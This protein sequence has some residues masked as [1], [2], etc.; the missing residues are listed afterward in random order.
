M[1]PVLTGEASPPGSEPAGDCCEACAAARVAAHADVQHSDPAARL[2]AWNPA[3]PRGPLPM[4]GS[5]AGERPGI[6]RFADRRIAFGGLAISAVYVATAAAS[7]LLPASTR[8]GSWLPAHLLLAGGAATAIAAVLPFFTAALGVAAP[9]RPAVRI[10]GIALVAFG[11]AAATVV[12]AFG[13]GEALPAALAGATFLAG[14]G[15]VAVATFAPLR[16]ALGPRRALFE[17]AYALALANVAVGVTVATFLVGGNHAVGTAWGAL[18][19]AHAW[20]NLVGFAGLVIATTLLHLAPTVVGTRLRPRASGR[21][22]VGGIALGA[23]LIA[24]GYA[25]GMDV[26]ARAGALAVIAAAL[27]VAGHGA[28]VQLD[29]ARGRWTTD[30]GW[31]RL[32][33][34]ALLAGQAWFGFGLAVAATRVLALGADPAGWSLQILVGPLLIGGVAQ[35]LVGA[36][37]HLLP[38]IG[39][40]DPLRHGWQRRLLGRAAVVRLATLNA[41]AALVAIGSWPAVAPGPGSADAAGLVSIGLA[42]AATGIGGTLGLLVLAAR[43]GDGAEALSLRGVRLRPGLTEPHDERDHE[44]Q[45]Q[46]QAVARTPHADGLDD[47]DLDVQE[48]DLEDHPGERQAVVGQEQPVQVR[49]PPGDRERQQDQRE[50]NA[51]D[52]DRHAGD[53]AVLAL[54]D[55]LAAVEGSAHRH[56]AADLHDRQVRRDGEADDIEHGE[57]EA[58]MDPQDRPDLGAPHHRIREPGWGQA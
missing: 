2:A 24:A 5:P 40:G 6:S 52:G 43:P 37:S 7:L 21:L 20:L 22:G 30:L 18:K 9:A 29:R 23:P 38:A 14:L 46:A 54:G 49:P 32:T 27:G 55:G 28:V 41:G 57:D 31:H 11:A 10:S 19:P 33:A 15:L 39:P 47:G 36:M 3:G 53:P 16:G 25:T 4:L 17:R 58:R 56:P 42:V 48:V 50:A 1:L 44:A 13:R 35:I 45:D 51:V 34:G 8:L 26:L 12:H